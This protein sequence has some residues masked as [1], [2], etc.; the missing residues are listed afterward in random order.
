[1]KL[2]RVVVPVAT[3]WT[4]STAPREID[5]P[6]LKGDVQ[7]WVADMSDADSITLGDGNRIAT[8]VL[9]NDEVLVLSEAGDWSEIVVPS[10]ADGSDI[11]GYPGWVKTALL[12]EIAPDAVTTTQV[13]VAS[14]L[15][16]LFDD[17]H[18]P[19]LTVSMGTR[20]SQLDITADAVKVAT[21]LG[22]GYIDKESIAMPFADLAMNE[23][24]VAMG[25]QFL[26]LRYLWGGISAYGFDCSGFVYTLHR[27]LGFELPRDADDQYYNGQPVAAENLQPGDLLF[28]AYEHGHGRIHHVG[29]Y[30]GHG[31]MIQ[32][33]TLGKQVDI[34]ALTEL[35]YAPEYVGA[36]RYWRA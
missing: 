20:F 36:R 7:Q 22:P 14:P 21:P 27:V 4:S 2:K 3:V 32:S 9:F 33:R 5:A 16:T 11:R 31:Q 18:D 30:I 28:F 12:T 17:H 34:A 29:M 8:Q 25:R 15:T 35:R 23:R 26:G 1:M 6:A 13:T 10:Q 24:L 19:L